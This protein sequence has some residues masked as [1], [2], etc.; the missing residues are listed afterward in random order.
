MKLPTDRV[1]IHMSSP[2]LFDGYNTFK[3]NILNFFQRPPEGAQSPVSLLKG[4]NRTCRT[5]RAL[6]II[7]RRKGR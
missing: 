5:F 2:E 7:V 4:T 6:R 1:F 3:N